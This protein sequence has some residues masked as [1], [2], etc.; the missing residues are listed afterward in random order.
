VERHVAGIDARGEVAEVADLL[1]REAGGAQA[2]VGRGE[3]LRGLGG[4]A[5]V[6]GVEP[7]VD[8]PG[9]LARELLEHDGAGERLEVRALGARGEAARPDGADDRGESRVGALE[10]GDRAAEIVHGA[11]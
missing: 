10:V 11:S 2:V 3:Q 4:A 6:E 7:R 5:A 8:R 9:G 1:P